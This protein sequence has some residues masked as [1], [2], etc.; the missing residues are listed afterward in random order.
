MRHTVALVAVLGLAACDGGPTTAADRMRAEYGATQAVTVGSLSWDVFLAQR[1]DVIYAAG[2]NRLVQIDRATGAVTEL[3][4]DYQNRQI[5]RIDAD[6]GHVYAVLQHGGGA[7]DVARIARGG[8]EPQLLLTRDLASFSVEAIAVRGGV[9]YA[10]VDERPPGQD[11]QRRLLAIPADGSGEPTA[12]PAPSRFGVSAFV[13]ADD[14]VFVALL[15]GAVWRLPY[16]GGE[17]VQVFASGPAIAAT[18]AA[19]AT[20]VYWNAGRLEPGLTEPHTLYF[21][22]RGADQ[23]AVLTADFGRFDFTVNELGFYWID[24]DARAIRAVAREELDTGSF[25]LIGTGDQPMRMVADDRALVYA[26][27]DDDDDL[28]DLAVN[29]LPRAQ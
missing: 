13:A 26:T 23:P 15:D 3:F 4:E 22:P 1:A 27:N 2:I 29:V 18:L 24:P 21:L 28:G 9:V 20:G 12:L 7:V 8:G 11:W 19:D 10:L 17:P 6:D 5:A 14:G 25:A 16:D